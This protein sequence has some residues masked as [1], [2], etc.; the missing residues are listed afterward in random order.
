MVKFSKVKGLAN[1]LAKADLSGPAC[2]QM[3]DFHTVGP[4]FT[5]LILLSSHPDNQPCR[6]TFDPTF[7]PLCCRYFAAI[8]DGCVR[9]FYAPQHV[10]PALN[11]DPALGKWLLRWSVDYP[12]DENPFR[13]KAGRRYRQQKPQT[14]K[15]R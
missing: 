3:E 15:R 14:S 4:P 2:G 6:Q 9:H 7:P 1:T 13:G 12:A 11:E 5:R 8:D 10:I